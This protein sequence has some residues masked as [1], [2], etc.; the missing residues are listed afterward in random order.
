MNIDHTN[1][2]NLLAMAIGVA[3]SLGQGVAQAQYKPTVELSDLNGTSGFMINGESEG[4]FFAFSVSAA[5]DMNK[6]GIGDVIIGA[7]GAGNLTGATYVVFGTKQGFHS[8]LE[9]SDLDGANGFKINGENPGD[10]SGFSVS[11]VGDINGDN[12]DDIIIGAVNGSPNGD[13][14]GVSY[15]VF[16]SDKSRFPNPLNLTNLDV[17]TGMV[18]N[19]VA[20][21]DNSG[22]SVSAAGDINGDG[23]GDLIIG[24]PYAENNSGASYLVFGSNQVL[25]K[26]LELSTLDGTNGFV[27]NGAN[28]DDY[29]GGSVSAAGDINHDDI[30]DLIIGA[31]GVDTTR[32]NA[33]ASYVVFG[34]KQPFDRSLELAS[35]NGSNGFVINGVNAQD[36]SGSSVSYAGD[37]NDDDIDDLVIGAPFANPTGNPVDNLSG[38]S[39]VIFGSEQDPST[40]LNLSTINGSNGVVINGVVAGGLSGQSVSA[41]GDINGDDIDDLIIGA[42]GTLV[43]D[44]SG[45]SYVVFGSKQNLSHPLSLADLNGK[46]GFV[47]NGANIGDKAGGSVSSV[48]DFN[49]DGINDLLIG[50]DGADPNGINSGASYVVF[51]NDGI[52]ADSFE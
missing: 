14:S 50:A 27:L 24:A 52:F 19:G 13:N 7:K 34:S 48:G 22:F 28:D 2:L 40:P 44:G 18:I 49:G 46:N 15:V 30:D 1:K 37:I 5:G 16:G 23:I 12:T 4:D 20:A 36:N 42:P 29:A 6:D 45:T 47:V 3:L 25:P 26:T 43:L 8:P 51:G 17:S 31:W 41:I 33:G 35:L 38:V 32:F 9:L 39:Y 11:A 21:G 10:S